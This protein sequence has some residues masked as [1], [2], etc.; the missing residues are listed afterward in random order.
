MPDLFDTVPDTE[1]Q[2]QQLLDL[3]DQLRGERILEPADVEF[4]RWLYMRLGETD[5]AVLLAAAHVGSLTRQGHVGTRIPIRTNEIPLFGEEQWGTTLDPSHRQQ[6]EQLV[7]QIAESMADSDVV[8]TPNDAQ[9]PLIFDRGYLYY[10]RYWMYE[11]TLADLLVEKARQPLPEFDT[12][13]AAEWITTLLDDNP[14]PE[15][16]NWSRI[17]LWVALR[18]RLMILT[19]GPGTG[20]TYTLVRLMALRLLLAQED[21]TEL[22]IALAAPTGKAAARID[23]SIGESLG[24][25]TAELPDVVMNQLPKEAQTIHRLLGTRRNQPE[26]RHNRDNPLPHD[27][28]IVDEASMVDIALMTKLLEALK[29][30]AQLILLGDKDQLASV[31]AGSVLGD[32][33][34]PLVTDTQSS[35]G[36]NQFSDSLLNELAEASI[37]KLP[38]PVDRATDTDLLDCMIQLTYSHRFK[39]APD[40]GNLADFINRGNAYEALQH[41]EQSEVTRLGHPDQL[42]DVLTF[43]EQWSYC[44]AR[45][46]ADHAQELFEAWTDFQILNAH[47]R[48]ALSSSTVNHLLDQWMRSRQQWG[49]QSTW[50]PGR[51]IMIT[52]NNYELNLFNGDI[53]ITVRDTQ[54]P[55]KLRIAFNTPEGIRLIA[56]AQLS[57]YDSAWALTV[58]K[59]QGSEFDEVLLILPDQPS[60]ILTR[61]LV[62]TALTRARSKF[63]VW[64]KVALFKQAVEQRIQ[65]TSALGERLWDEG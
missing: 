62:Y 20:K 63:T 45:Y 54:E 44:R 30:E 18:R 34:S 32:I 8:G 29:P 14:Q 9:H 27:M 24:E 11:C 60:P 21:Q 15:A 12:E 2:P 10:Q 42:R 1:M 61:E 38:E 6:L 46:T 53:G 41:V 55:E 36:L 25:L 43:C 56:P 39:D 31:E 23:E 4:P 57:S 64:G 51:P 58:H 28:I 52:E 65:R 49:E 13:Q 59:S 22:N 35:A 7:E 19:G 37:S 26:F 16:P 48:G 47:R 40:I 50:Y 3:L 17:A 33:C 5:P